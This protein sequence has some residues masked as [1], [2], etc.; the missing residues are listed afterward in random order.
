MSSVSRRVGGCSSSWQAAG[1]R[2]EG[3]KGGEGGDVEV[4]LGCLTR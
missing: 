4:E 2:E 1:M 3:M